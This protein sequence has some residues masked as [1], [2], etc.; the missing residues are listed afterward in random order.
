M[1][2]LADTAPRA[3]IDRPFAQCL[4][5]LAALTAVRLVGLALSDVDFY[6]DESQYWAWSR[7]FAFGYFS[8][9]PLLAWVIAGA[10]FVCG[11]SE[12]CIRAPSPL[13]YLGTCVVSYWIAE[14]LY[15]RQTA[16]WVALCLG[17]NGAVAFSSRIISTDVPLLFFWAVALL[18]YV[19]LLQGGTLKWGIVLG[20]SFGLG[21]LAK[22]PMLCFAIGVAAAAAIDRDARNLLRSRALWVAAGIG[23]MLILPNAIWNARNGFVT[24]QHVGDNIDG[25]GAV[26]SLRL[27]FEFLAS[28][29]AVVGPVIFTVLLI[30][31]VRAAKP[32]V[33][34]A[35]RLMLCFALPVLAIVTATAFTTRAHAN[36]AAASIVAA[37]ILGVAVLVRRAA[38]R[39]IGLSIGIGAVVQVA[40]LLGDPNARRLTV[41][42]LK[43]PDVYNRTLGWRELGEEVE[44]LARRTGARTIVSDNRA[45]IAS[46]LY[47]QHNTGRAVL[48]WPRGP[49]PDHHFDLTRRLTAAAPEPILFV[50]S[51]PSV[52]R[53]VSHYRNVEAL[54][55]FA[56]RT[57]P[58]MT[59]RY[60]AYSLSGPIGEIRPV[61]GC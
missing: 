42:W 15:D 2:S 10:E 35:D 47:Y 55:P 20:L 13:F 5:I 39:W 4:A 3:S 11:S 16:F 31:L 57:G 17:F 61:T 54:G 6:Y 58:T 33:T 52:K 26:F 19:K 25:G 44:K 38:W 22:Y 21:T 60:F 36:W 50:S 34:R 40:V 9:P 37:N 30:V 45:E 24:I 32:D 51:C 59:R 56:T 28:Q 18:A 49:V 41:S 8:K 29:F 53:F 12:A 48:A 14:A 46:L 7:E 1:A 23:V 27:G 43:S